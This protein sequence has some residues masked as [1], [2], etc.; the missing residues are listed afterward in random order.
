MMGMKKKPYLWVGVAIALTI[1]L[2]DGCRK[3]KQTQQKDENPILRNAKVGMFKGEVE[4][5]Y[6][7]PLHVWE[8]E[9]CPLAFLRTIEE[10]W[11]YPNPFQG[12]TPAMTFLY[13]D[14]LEKLLAI[15]RDGRG[16]PGEM[17][18]E[19]RGFLVQSVGNRFYLRDAALE[20]VDADALW[21]PETVEKRITVAPGLI[22]VGTWAS[23][24]I[25]VTVDLTSAAPLRGD[26]E[27]WRFT[28]DAIVT[29]RGD[30]LILE[31]DLFEPLGWVAVSPGTYRVRVYF[32][33]GSAV[34]PGNRGLDYYQIRLWPE[35]INLPQTGKAE[36]EPPESN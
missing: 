26:G 8:S 1:P 34:D 24:Y 29:F 25:P 17:N 35:T 36:P 15:D 19:T 14:N 23:G 12:S 31:G 9:A 6:G 28:Q 22:G 33:G 30:A 16:I 10:V 7:Q 3:K 13:F 4:E 11:I 2:L 27:I 5:V 21:T 20:T 32:G 18:P